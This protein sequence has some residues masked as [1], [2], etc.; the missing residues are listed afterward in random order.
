MLIS[1]PIIKF[2]QSY[3]RPIS[4]GLVIEYLQANRSLVQCPLGEMLC[5]LEQDALI[6]K[7]AG[8]L[9]SKW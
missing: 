1:V 4:G 6:T 8:Y 2:S 3:F 7:S 9:P 5:V